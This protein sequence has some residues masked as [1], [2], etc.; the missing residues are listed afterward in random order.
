MLSLNDTSLKMPFRAEGCAWC[1]QQPSVPLQVQTLGPPTTPGR[2]RRRAKP[3]SEAVMLL[4]AESQVK[5]DICGSIL[6]Y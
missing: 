3:D 5:V 1:S 6:L 2:G 4:H